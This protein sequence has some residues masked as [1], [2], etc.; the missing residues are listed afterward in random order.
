MS[1][2]MSI[3]A[4]VVVVAMVAAVIRWSSSRARP[5]DLG[6]VSSQWISEHRLAQTQDSRQ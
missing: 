4:G 2:G 6:A 1:D 5:A 3:L